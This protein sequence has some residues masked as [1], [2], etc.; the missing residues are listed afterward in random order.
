MS[1]NPERR[2]PDELPARLDNGAKGRS[3]FNGSTHIPPRRAC[4]ETLH[5]T[6]HSLVIRALPDGPRAPDGTLAFTSGV[7]IY[8]PPGYSTSGVRYPVVYLLHG[9][10][11]D[12]GDA[13][14]QGHLRATM[15]HLIAG[16]A[17]AAAI[18]VMPD[19]DD[20]QWYDGIDG[21]IKNET[22]VMRD[23][24]PYVDRHYR[25]IATRGGRAITG[26]SNGGFGS[27]LFA[28]KHP[29]AFVAAGGMSS[30]LDWLGARGLGD[31]NGA[32]YHANRP[33]ELVGGLS[34]TDVI[35][36]IATRC[37]NPDPAALC[38]TQGLDETFLPANLGFVA[39]LRNAAGHTAV[40]DFREEDGAH[41]W[42]TWARW[43]RNDQL[44]FLLA[45]LA[46]PQR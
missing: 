10:G 6:P 21:R 1:A 7:C 12:A 36:Q 30:N 28:S 24:I 40:L 11:G 46:N 8:L 25:T 45:R 34:K 44:P 26:V 3:T 15:D 2:A 33:V 29:G 27:M 37:T 13:V 23:V 5:A 38:V 19:G 4:G 42:S 17:E 39:R 32:Y 18:V 9:G 41:Q 20:A 31:P 14:A 35:L 43:L 16:D 22:Y